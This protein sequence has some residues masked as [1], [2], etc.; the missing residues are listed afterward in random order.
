MFNILQALTGGSPV[1]QFVEY[2]NENGGHGFERARS[3]ENSFRKHR[4]RPNLGEIFVDIEDQ[5]QNALSTFTPGCKEMMNDIRYIQQI[6]I[7]KLN[8]A[9]FH[10]NVLNIVDKSIFYL[11][12]F[13]STCIEIKLKN[14]ISLFRGMRIGTNSHMH[15]FLSAMKP[16]FGMEREFIH[17]IPIIHTD[18]FWGFSTNPEIAA[19]FALPD[20]DKHYDENGG[21][22]EHSDLSIMIVISNIRGSINAMPGSG[23]ETE[24]VIG[25]GTRLQVFS[26]ELVTIHDS[27]EVEREVLVLYVTLLQPTT[28]CSRELVEQNAQILQNVQLETIEDTMMNII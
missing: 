27:H 16:I 6:G 4:V 17:D 5:Y 15:T 19:R 22:I 12:Y 21:Q 26:S 9:I 20:V 23:F 25:P 13:M 7:S 28:G 18:G 8:N 24:F 11:L 3:L 10:N 14:R 1:R 2:D